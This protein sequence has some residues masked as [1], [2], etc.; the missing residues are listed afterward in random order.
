MLSISVI[1]IKHSN[2]HTLNEQSRRNVWPYVLNLKVHVNFI[3]YHC[4][5]KKSYV[6]I[7]NMHPRLY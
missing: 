3:S 6:D 5:T 4:L 1:L 2:D 7:L